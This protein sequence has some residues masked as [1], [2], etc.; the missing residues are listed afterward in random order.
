MQDQ[1]EVLESQALEQPSTDDAGTG[2]ETPQLPR[3]ASK[4]ARDAC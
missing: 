1:R 4:R 3:L 2:G